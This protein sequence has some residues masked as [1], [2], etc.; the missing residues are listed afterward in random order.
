M[1]TY[2]NVTRYPPSRIDHFDSEKEAV[3]YMKKVEPGVP[4]VSLNGRSPHNQLPYDQFVKWKKINNFKE[5]E[6]KK[7]YKPDGANP[8]EIICTKRS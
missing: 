6:Y 4:L 5:Y 7:M 1:V 3:D 2:R 8:R